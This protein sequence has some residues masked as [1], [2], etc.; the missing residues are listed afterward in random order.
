MWPFKK[1]ELPVIE[2]GSVEE[3][4]ELNQQVESK[5]EGLRKKFVVGEQIPWKGIWFAVTKVDSELIEIAPIRTTWQKE[6]QV[7]K[8]RIGG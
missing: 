7:K 3:V 8:S 4:A 1:E 2:V 6:K 5:V